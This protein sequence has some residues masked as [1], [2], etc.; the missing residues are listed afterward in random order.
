MSPADVVGGE[1]LECA[2]CS[3]RTFL[4]RSLGVAVLAAL[5]SACVAAAVPVTIRSGAVRLRPE[6]QNALADNGYMRLMPAG[7]PDPIYLLAV[8]GGYAALSP[9][10]THQGCTVEVQGERLVCPCHGSTY[11]R[12]GGLLRGP[13]EEPLRSFPVHVEGDGTLTITLEDV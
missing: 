2:G 3:R 6:D 1:T 7:R 9:L 4:A 10:C 11:D 12:R 8:D 13:A 5:P